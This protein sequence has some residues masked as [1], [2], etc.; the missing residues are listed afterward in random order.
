[1]Q[2]LSK[3][4]TNQPHLNL[5]AMP[6]GLGSSLAQIEQALAAGDIDQ[7]LKSLNQ[8]AGQ[9]DTLQTE[10]EKSRGGA[11]EENRELAQKLKDFK[12]DL[13][14]VQRD[15]T[16]IANETDGL[17]RETRRALERRAPATSTLLDELRAETR[18]AK[19]QLDQ[20]PQIGLARES[21]RGRLA[22]GRKGAYGG[23]R[24]E[25]LNPRTS[26]RRCTP[27]SMRCR[28]WGPSG[29]NWSATASSVHSPA[30]SPTRVR[31]PP[32]SRSAQARLHLQQATTP[33]QSVRDKLQKLFPDEKSLL[34]AEEKE[35]L[36]SASARTGPSPGTNP[37]PR[38]KA[39]S[40][41]QGRAG[42]RSRRSRRVAHR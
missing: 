26:T 30:G 32:N 20:I 31:R 25:R 6:K 34:G 40:D 21:L 10:L 37:V 8:L 33:L 14:E 41:W 7:A 5:E 24:F 38:A 42:L 13:D 12:D 18:H 22:L 15:Q 11:R 4:L 29:K 39:R 1:M 36:G 17:R 35:Q 16:K 2:Q 3:G 28:R 19:D 27:P 9:L 23:A